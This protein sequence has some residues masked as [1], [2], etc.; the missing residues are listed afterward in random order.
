VKGSAK[1]GKQIPVCIS[2]SAGSL[3]EKTE[4]MDI[5]NPV[6]CLVPY[7]ILVLLETLIRIAPIYYDRRHTEVSEMTNL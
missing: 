2:A 6:M 5:V 1:K 4:R 3:A 7:R